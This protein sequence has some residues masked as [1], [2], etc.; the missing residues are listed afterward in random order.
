M[1]VQTVFHPQD[2]LAIGLALA[3]I[4][5]A[6]R[7]RWVLAGGFCALAILSQQFSLLIA[8]PLSIV[9]PA[10]PGRHPLWGQP[11]SQVRSWLFRSLP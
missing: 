10:T 8:A 4:A 9:A 7:D 5:C 1:S 2:M 11:W 6:R 3:G